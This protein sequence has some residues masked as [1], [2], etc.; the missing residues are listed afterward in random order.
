MEETP[1]QREA[2]RDVL[3]RVAYDEVVRALSA[4]QAAIDSVRGRA[5]LLFSAAAVTTS[6]LGG[7]ALEGG[8]ASP[9]SWLALTSF[10]C[11]AAAS[12]AILRPRR[13]EFSA[14]SSALI[15]SYVEV[16]GS[17]PIEELHRDLTL[18]LHSS[19][20]ENRARLDG[21][22]TLFQAASGLTTIEVILWIIAIASSA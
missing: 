13:W 18:H 2:D 11:V 14:D 4:Q 5:G 7:Q 16:A 3:Y 6:F 22:S 1:N 8:S 19:Y 17:V 9:V 21:L 15:Q 10:L 12:L 20:L